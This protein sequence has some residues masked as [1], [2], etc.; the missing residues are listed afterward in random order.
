M[1]GFGVRVPACGDTPEAA[2][3]H[4]APQTADAISR[5]RQRYGLPERYVL[6]V[7]TLEPRKNLARLLH[8][9]EPLVRD[10]LIDGVVLVGSRGWLYDEFFGAL[11]ALDWRDRVVLPGFVED[12][13]LPA[14]YAGAMMTAQPSLYE[15]FGLPVLEA[16]GS[17]SPVACSNVSSLP[18][19]GG[20]AALYF[21][22][23]EVDSMSDTLR[24]LATDEHLRESLRARGLGQASHFSWRRTAELTISLYE[25]VIAGR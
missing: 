7:G 13:D 24:A 19:V 16:M 21:D 23:T 14:V 11:A 17:G 2:A 5:V 4:F 12:A 6:A 18:E 1:L 3:P 9:C 22:P 25:K 15:G 20:D 8:A 10:R